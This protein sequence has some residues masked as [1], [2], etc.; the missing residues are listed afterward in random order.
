MFLYVFVVT[1][2]VS[3]HFVTLHSSPLKGDSAFWIVL[4]TGN[5]YILMVITSNVG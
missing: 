2:S 3:L 1:P 4:Y 5:L